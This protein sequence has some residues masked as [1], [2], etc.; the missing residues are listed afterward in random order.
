MMSKAN[1]FGSAASLI[2]MTAMVAGCA[3]TAPKVESDFVKRSGDDIGLASK[4]ALALSAR[5]YP[6]AILYAERAVARTPDDAGFRAVLGNTYFASGR[7]HSAEMAYKDALS[8][9][10]EQPQVV[11]KLALAEIAVG[12]AAAARNTLAAGRYTLSAA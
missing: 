1:R 9:Y 10:S 6:N 7:F 2:A 8:I 11:L 4:A 12:N 3:T 5:D